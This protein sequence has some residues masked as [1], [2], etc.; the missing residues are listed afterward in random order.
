MRPTFHDQR[1]GRRWDLALATRG[2]VSHRAVLSRARRK[3]EAVKGV[4]DFIVAGWP[5]P[6]VAPLQPEWYVARPLDRIGPTNGI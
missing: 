1:S 3:P 4:Q 2:A 5:A 6:T